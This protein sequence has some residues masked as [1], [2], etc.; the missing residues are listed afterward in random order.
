MAGAAV[1][2]MKD[3]KYFFG[4][5]DAA[6]VFSVT[7]RQAGHQMCCS[8]V[9]GAISKS[10]ISCHVVLLEDGVAFCALQAIVSTDAGSRAKSSYSCGCAHGGGP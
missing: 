1:N 5:C 2:F 3:Q 4:Q 9:A 6:F 8:A 7:N 10:G